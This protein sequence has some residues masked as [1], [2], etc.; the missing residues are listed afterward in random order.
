M[1]KVFILSGLP[2]S[3]KS[4]WSK[5]YIKK[6]PNTLIVSRD[7][8]RTSLHGGKY[9]FDDKIEPH[10]CT[11]N[12]T[13]IEVLLETK[14]DIIIDETNGNRI[15]RAVLISRIQMYRTKK[16]KIIAVVF[17]E[18]DNLKFRMKEPRGYTKTKWK[19]IINYMR[20]NWQPVIEE[21]GFDQIIYI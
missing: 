11:I 19:Q 18:H 7:D 2:G 15:R 13:M 5:S 20:K 16:V 21:E 4:F 10:I 9:V 14:K 8:I 6:H 17:K 1:Q 12:D 3:G